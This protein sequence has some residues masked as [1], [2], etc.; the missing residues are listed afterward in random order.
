MLICMY[1]GFA[2][3]LIMVLQELLS[4]DRIIYSLY[5]LQAAFNHLKNYKTHAADKS[6]RGI[7]FDFVE[8]TP[9][10]SGFCWELYL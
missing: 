2:N 3:T 6:K 9:F 8:G 10:L 5:L 1:L 7:A 4:A